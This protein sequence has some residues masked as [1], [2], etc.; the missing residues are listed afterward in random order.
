MQIVAEQN[1][2]ANDAEF[3]A[4]EFDDAETIGAESNIAKITGMTEVGVHRSRSIGSSTKIGKLSLRLGG[5]RDMV[6]HTAS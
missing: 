4:L 1:A 6:D 5:G 3:I 2:E